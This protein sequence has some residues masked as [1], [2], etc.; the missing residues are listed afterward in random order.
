MGGLA[1]VGAGRGHG[2]RAGHMHAAVKSNQNSITYYKVLFI[3]DPSTGRSDRRVVIRSVLRLP[4][5]RN[6]SSILSSL[7][8]PGQEAWQEH[9]TFACGR[10]FVPQ[11]AGAAQLQC[12]RHIS[13]PCNLT[14]HH[15]Y[16]YNGYNCTCT[17][18]YRGYCKTLRTL[19][20]TI[21]P[22]KCVCNGT[23]RRTPAPCA[24]ESAGLPL[25]A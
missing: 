16:G 18:M 6:T 5:A 8:P 15:M 11:P 7:A 3:I 19:Y 20:C 22:S 23:T 1:S 25:E 12:T 24:P 2:G 10:I 17:C 21:G 14:S 4:R 13:Q 9:A